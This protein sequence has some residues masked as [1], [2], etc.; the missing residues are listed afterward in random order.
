[1]ASTEF[2][3]LFEPLALRDV[4]VRNRVMQTAHTRG[5]SINGKESSR[6]LAYYLARGRGGVGLIVIGGRT[7]HGSAEGPPQ[8]ASG[9]AHGITAHDLR[10][11]GALRDAGVVSIAQIN[12]FGNNAFGGVDF[13]RE[14]LSASDVPSPLYGTIPRPMEADD[15]AEIIEAWAAAAGRARDGGFDGLELLF[16][17]GYLVHQFL[18]PLFNHR[19]DG[20]GGRLENRARLARE[21]LSAVRERVG[22][23][24]LVGVRLSAADFLPGGLEAADV[25]RVAQWLRD[26]SRV[27][28]FDV[29]M[30]EPGGMPIPALGGHPDGW[31]ASHSAAFKSAFPDVPVF[32]AGAVR[33]PGLAERILADGEADMVALTREQIADPDWVAK[34]RSGRQHQIYHCIRANQGCIARVSHGMPLSCTVNPMVGREAFFQARLAP[35]PHPQHWL[36]VGGGPAGLKSAETLARRGHRVTLAERSD[37][38]GGQVNLIA[39]VDGFQDMGLIVSDLCAQ[40]DELEVS[41]ALRTP[42]HGDAIADFEADRIVLATGAGAD[43]RGFA[44]ALGAIEGVSQHHVCTGVDVLAGGAAAGRRVAVIDT[45]GTR[46]TAAVCQVL[47]EQGSEVMLVSTLPSVV[48]QTLFTYDHQIVYRRLLVDGFEAVLNSWV[49]RIDGPRLS[50][51]NL[52]TGHTSLREP[53]DSV[54]LVGQRRSERA[55]YEALNSA[56]VPAIRVGDCV[57]PRGLDE[58]I[59]DGFVAGLEIAAGEF[60]DRETLEIWPPQPSVL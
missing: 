58:A 48:P 8:F 24:F 2:P 45:Q 1:M 49:T 10:I 34:V 55:L 31:L 57:T 46:Y 23:E 51:V 50:L 9:F 19:D 40:L 16:G 22:E 38:L 29:T 26:T 60:P 43:R 35:T 20:Y 17:H 37:R 4:V 36:V 59:F 41:I 44:T 28:F 30:G 53:F 5:W 42:V 13:F 33:D 7:I 18:S 25:L 11:T 12:H 39:A 56:G 6:D 21:I 32:V 47:L 52:Y 54:V 27:D 3:H 14:A 15:F